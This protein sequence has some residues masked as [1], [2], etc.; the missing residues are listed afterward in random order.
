MTTSF[1]MR[2][3]K[4]NL[5]LSS[6]IARMT[7]DMNVRSDLCFQYT[8]MNKSDIKIRQNKAPNRILWL[9]LHSMF[10]WLHDTFYQNAWSE[11]DNR[12]KMINKCTDYVIY[13]LIDSI[14]SQEN[15]ISTFILLLLHMHFQRH[16]NECS[17]NLSS[18]AIQFG[19]ETKFTSAEQ[20]MSIQCSMFNSSKVISEP[21]RNINN[22]NTC[23]EHQKLYKNDYFYKLDFTFDFALS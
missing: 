17:T 6:H 20:R 18:S 12:S 7:N 19:R 5:E 13:L 21:I 8:F 2:A 22:V 23:F 3:I 9:E 14:L 11:I 10:C 16:P 1:S 15:L 4:F